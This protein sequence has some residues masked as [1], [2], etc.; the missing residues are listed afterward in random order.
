MKA[1]IP[2]NLP[3]KTK[4]KTTMKDDTLSK[5]KKEGPKL[6]N[7]K[8]PAEMTMKTK[9]KD[10][11]ASLAFF[12]ACEKMPY[13]SCTGHR[14]YDNIFYEYRRLDLENNTH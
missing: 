5:K 4:A 3:V 1:L 8:T 14:S 10:V 13:S 7:V 2:K 6:A 12:T 11:T 9:T